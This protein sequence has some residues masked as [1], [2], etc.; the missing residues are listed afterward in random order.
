M[1]D[2]APLVTRGNAARA[3]RVRDGVHGGAVEERRR[4]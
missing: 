4:A 3:D 1:P 2:G